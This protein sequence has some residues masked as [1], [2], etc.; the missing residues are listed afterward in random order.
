MKKFSIAIVVACLMALTAG[1][2]SADPVVNFSQF[3]D[4]RAGGDPGNPANHPFG[5]FIVQGQP[6]TYQHDV[7]NAVPSIDIGAGHYVTDA[8]LKLYFYDEDTDGIGNYEWVTVNFNGGAGTWNIGTYGDGSDDV[9]WATYPFAVD[10]AWING[11]NGIL[12]VEVAVRNVGGTGDIFLK[13][14]ELSGTAVVPV[15][16]AV[17]LGVLGLGAAGMRLRKNKVA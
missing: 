11:N 15:P 5:I 7:L 16:G 8:T 13:T 2:V 6:F 4:F 14:S 3:L 12:A 1:T 17:L 9:D 10:V